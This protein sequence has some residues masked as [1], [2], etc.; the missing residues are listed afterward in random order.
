VNKQRARVNNARVR[1]VNTEAAAAAA[2][3]SPEA[4]EIIFCHFIIFLL[5]AFLFFSSFSFIFLYINNTNI[6]GEK[7]CSRKKI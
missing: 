1:L 7:K 5:L 2:A 6:Y 4:V 3:D